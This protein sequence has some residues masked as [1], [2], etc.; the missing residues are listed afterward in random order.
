MLS[1]IVL[2]AML[3]QGSLKISFMV[4][5]NQEKLVLKLSVGVMSIIPATWEVEAGGLQVQ[6]QSS[7]S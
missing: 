2:K 3:H 6:S 7:K 4:E 5:S 1:V